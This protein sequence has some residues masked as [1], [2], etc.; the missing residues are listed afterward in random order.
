M[1]QFK[2]GPT[3]A[4]KKHTNSQCDSDF[5]KDNYES[6]AGPQS[7]LVKKQS[8]EKRGFS[9]QNSDGEPSASD[10]PPGIPFLMQTQ[11]DEIAEADPCVLKESIA[12]G[13]EELKCFLM[14]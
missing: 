13:G 11:T 14:I 10:A 4:T 2:S 5:S 6:Q 7:S 3:S 1:N 12:C 9:N 8:G